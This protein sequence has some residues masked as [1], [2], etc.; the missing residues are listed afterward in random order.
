MMVEGKVLLEMYE[1]EKEFE[2]QPPIITKTT[3]FRNE[4]EDQKRIY[5]GVLFVKSL[6]S[7]KRI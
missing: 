1:R 4:D 7:K 2:E 3:S 5:D 6:T